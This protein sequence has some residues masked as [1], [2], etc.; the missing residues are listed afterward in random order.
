M[1]RRSI[2]TGSS[3]PRA[4]AGREL[5]SGLK[6]AK[7]FIASKYWVASHER[8]SLSGCLG[9]EHAIERVAVNQRQRRSR[10]RMVQC[11]FEQRYPRFA[12]G[13]Q[14]CACPGVQNRSERDNR[15]LGM[16]DPEFP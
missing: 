8:K 10:G 4:T 2:P 3:G 9:D 12:G 11:D 13:L 5:G 15:L 14:K 7:A 6:D 1:P 16:L